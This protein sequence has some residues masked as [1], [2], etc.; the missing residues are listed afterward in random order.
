VDHGILQRESLDWI[1]QNLLRAR[2]STQYE[3]SE[4][5]RMLPRSRKRIEYELKAAVRLQARNNAN[6]S[7]VVGHPILAALG[8]ARF[9]RTEAIDIDGTGDRSHSVLDE[10]K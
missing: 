2:A 4:F 8:C 6:H 1:M 10:T 7:C 5:G 9:A 3:Q